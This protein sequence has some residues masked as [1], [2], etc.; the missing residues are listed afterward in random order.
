MGNYQIKCWKLEKEGDKGGEIEPLKNSF[1]SFFT[2]YNLIIKQSFDRKSDNEKKDKI[3]IEL[4]IYLV[5]EIIFNGKKYFG[6]DE[7]PNYAA[8]IVLKISD[9]IIQNF[10]DH[11]LNLPENLKKCFPYIK[12]VIGFSNN[13]K[14]LTNDLDVIY[15]TIKNEEHKSVLK[16]DIIPVI[17]K[18]MD[19]KY[20]FRHPNLISL[21]I[22]DDYLTTEFVTQMIL[23]KDSLKENPNF[24][25][26]YVNAINSVMAKPFYTSSTLLKEA[27]YEEEKEEI[28][29]IKDPKNEETEKK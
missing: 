18:F 29:D 27:D 1:K 8:S 5:G 4:L 15:N 25:L 10:P 3:W 26:N 14:T 2:S 21:N 6:V 13:W 20:K 17:V 24:N 22:L 11:C 23:G 9:I 12:S 7:K 19:D 28:D 16:K